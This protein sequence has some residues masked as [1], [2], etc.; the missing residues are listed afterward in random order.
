[1]QPGTHGEGLELGVIISAMHSYCC[2]RPCSPPFI[3]CSILQIQMIL[4]SPTLG[5]FVFR[6][7]VTQKGDVLFEITLPT[8]L[9]EPVKLIMEY[10]D[11]SNLFRRMN[12]TTN[13]AY[14]TNGSFL[15]LEPSSRVPFERFRVSVWLKV[16]SIIGPAVQDIHDHG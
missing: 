14:I 2:T 10:I 7:D 6:V 16:S 8:P 1:M 12:V 5:F 4:V 9:S 13:A 15:H 3:K 11:L